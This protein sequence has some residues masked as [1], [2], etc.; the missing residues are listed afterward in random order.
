MSANNQKE[1]LLH[2]AVKRGLVAVEDEARLGAI[3]DGRSMGVILL[4]DAGLRPE[5]I[6]QL[7]N[8]QKKNSIPTRVGPYQ[9]TDHLGN[10]GMSIVYKGFDPHTRQTVAIKIL[11]PRVAAYGLSLPRFHREAR[12]AGAV[13]HPQVIRCL[14]TGEV[15]GHPYQILEF[16]AGGDVATRLHAQGGRLETRRVL[17]IGRDCALGLAA[18]HAA[19]MIHRDVKPANIFLCATG[20]AKIADLG[21]ARH[22]EPDDQLTLPGHCVGTPWYMSPEQARGADGIDGRTDVYSLGATLYHLVT[23]QP[24]FRGQT[25][26]AVITAVLTQELQPVLQLC[27]NLD[28]A[29]ATVIQRC[30]DKNRD[31]R[32]PDASAVAQALEEILN[33]LTRPIET[34]QESS[35]STAI[36][37]PYQMWWN[38][39]RAWL[40]AQVV[41]KQPHAR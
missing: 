15:N 16:M 9:I 10:G 13:A 18:I 39:A 7:R 5:V 3:L 36:F 23:G 6:R 1:G 21:L 30:L 41:R 8:E 25:P 24:P 38:R 12:S 32:F 33:P 14:D 35:L 28:P 2:L 19:G 34:A 31:R 40:R 20:N 37:S 26:R 27:P 29:L 11:S 4:E 22:I 17:E